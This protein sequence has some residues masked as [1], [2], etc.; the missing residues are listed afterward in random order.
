MGQSL[1]V[2]SMALCQDECSESLP[3]PPPPPPL[4]H[5][6]Q[7]TLCLACQGGP[8][9]DNVQGN[10]FIVITILLTTLLILLFLLI[11]IIL[12]CR[13]WKS[14]DYYIWKN[15]YFNYRRRLQSRRPYLTYS[16]DQF[17]SLTEARQFYVQSQLEKLKTVENSY[18]DLTNN[19]NN[20]YVQIVDIRHG[21]SR[22]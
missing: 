7:E 13:R 8:T 10:T 2:S 9:S 4:L 19:K 21:E 1:S 12:L 5:P 20:I 17:N 3:R 6:Q 16:E 15:T 11:F 22:Q 14:L 18:T